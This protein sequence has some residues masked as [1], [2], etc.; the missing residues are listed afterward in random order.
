VNNYGKIV[1]TPFDEAVANGKQLE[2]GLFE[3]AGALAK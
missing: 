2:P 1:T 3:L